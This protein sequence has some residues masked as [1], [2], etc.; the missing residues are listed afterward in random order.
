MDRLSLRSLSLLHD[1]RENL[2]AE[3]RATGR[4]V[5]GGYAGYMTAAGGF[6]PP[7]PGGIRLTSEAAPLLCAGAI[8]YRSMR[9]SNLQEGSAL[10]LMGFGGSNHP[11]A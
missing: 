8:G 10:G 11:R 7:D 2:C 1:R 4:D 9:L 5:D 3:F 6:H